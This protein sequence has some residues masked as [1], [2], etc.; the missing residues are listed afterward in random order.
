MPRAMS[1]PVSRTSPARP[2]RTGERGV[3]RITDF[4]ASDFI[5]FDI[6]AG[7]AGRLDPHAFV[8]GANALDANDRFIYSAPSGGLYY[9]PDGNGAAAKVLFA[10]LD[11]KFALTAAD[12]ILL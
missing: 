8:T 11:N 7:P 4:D 2:R 6:A 10:V 1:S 5:R 12:I 3:D 9:D